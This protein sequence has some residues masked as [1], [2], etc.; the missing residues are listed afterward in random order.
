MSR[1]IPSTL[2]AA[3]VLAV[4]IF[5]PATSL[6]AA[7]F[8]D[9]GSV[10]WAAPSIR[11]LAAE[12]VVKGSSATTF[13]PSGAITREAL[14]VILARAFALT[15]TGSLLSYPDAPSIDA[16]AKAGVSAMVARGWLKGVGDLI[17]PRGDVTRAEAATFIGRA[18]GLT[19]QAGS[20]AFGDEASIPTWAAGYVDLLAKD[21]ILTGFPDGTFR[22]GASVTRAQFAVMLSRAEPYIG[23]LAGVPGLVAGT[24]GKFVAPD[25]ASLAISSSVAGPYG[26]FTLASGKL[27]SL[28][29]GASLTFGT[30][31]GNLYELEPGDMVAGIV[32]ASGDVAQLID[33]TPGPTSVTVENASQS[34]LYLSNGATLGVTT[35]QTVSL[36][37]TTASVTP[38]ELIGAMVA[39]GS[40]SSA[41]DLSSVVLRAV[42]ATVDSATSAEATFTVTGGGGAF[43]PDGSLT[44]ALTAAT[45]YQSGG[46]SATA[47]PAPGTQVTLMVQLTDTGKASLLAAIW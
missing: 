3:L 18:M 38:D 39:P 21:G 46:V 4:M 24:V 37:A 35:P 40:T 30:T 43:L 1:H 8:S 10:S 23:N 5:A 2:G 15:G 14:A 47:L 26:G 44:A 20:A 9:L 45:T 31:A 12:G 25:D 19:P 28:A 7:G 29:A 34:A 42:S 17:L 27:E 32:G 13:D 33:F 36:G 16:W 41:L 22:P 11:L 6:R